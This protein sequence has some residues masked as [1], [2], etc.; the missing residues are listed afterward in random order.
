MS[1]EWQHLFER[2]LAY[3]RKHHLSAKSL[4][5]LLDSRLLVARSGLSQR[6][7]CPRM[8]RGPVP[9]EIVQLLATS[10]YEENA[11]HFSPH[12]PLVV[13]ENALRTAN[14][15]E[16]VYERVAEYFT[17]LTAK[18]I[19]TVYSDAAD[20]LLTVHVLTDLETEDVRSILYEIDNWLFS[21]DHFKHVKV[22]RWENA[23][24]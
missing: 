11:S 13:L 16:L 17:Y 23:S 24:S 6:F 1:L 15:D 9:A 10:N 3:R 21:Q 5:L 4:L 20:S 14:L 19:S 2:Q 18:R 22:E 7:L 12:E 8:W